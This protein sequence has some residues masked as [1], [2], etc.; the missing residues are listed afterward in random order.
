M[1]S[2][3]LLFFGTIFTI[4]SG[5]C[6]NY[7]R[8]ADARVALP[9]VSKNSPSYNLLDFGAVPDGKTLNTIAIQKAL[10]IASG[11]NATLVVPRGVF[12]TGTLFLKSNTHLEL[13]AGAVLLGSQK[14]EDYSK[15]TWGHHEDRTPWHLLVVD[16]AKN[17]RISGLGTI[18]GN[19]HHFWE[20]E[21]KHD[22]AFYRE[23]EFRPSPMVEITNSENVIL[24]NI[25]LRNPAGWCLHPFNSRNVKITGITI[26]NNLFG[27]NADGI[28]IGGCQDVLISNCNISSGDDAIALKTTEDSGP[29]ER[30]TITNCILE[31]NCVAVR[32]GF[33]S[34]QDIRD[35]TVTN[36]IVKNC[37][38]VVDIRSVEGAVIERI[39]I[40][41]VTG[42]TNSGW[43]VNRVIE[44]D[45]NEVPDLYPIA[46]KEHPNFGKPKPILKRGA[47]RDISL[48]DFDILTDGRIMLC[49]KDGMNLENVV[50]DNIHLRFAM[51]DN[52]I[53]LSQKAEGNGGYFKNS[54]DLRTAPAAMAVKN[55]KGFTLDHFR[56]SWPVYPVADD[57]NLLKT[58]WRFLEPEW[59]KGNEA[60]V[61]SGEMKPSFKAFWGKNIQGGFVNLSQVAASE[62]G[63]E[64]AEFISCEVKQEK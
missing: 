22:W 47:I 7:K 12:Y 52:C 37:S 26:A 56:I 41:H 42:Q 31:T 51:I 10:D 19:G 28:D 58:D 35:V 17:V 44:V 62:P 63:Q 25:T 18:D 30:I 9:A 54:P 5:V 59:Y 49:A 29:C 32:V 53:A 33:E 20:K 45:L 4:S 38:R 14:I 2:V 43:P 13:S 64:K 46:I 34:R 21:R 15:L 11:A 39:R 60:K 40:S 55:V 57:W 1:K 36:L 24:E 23:I 6:Q 8:Q 50:M 27:P 48:T 61:R 3:F 16:K